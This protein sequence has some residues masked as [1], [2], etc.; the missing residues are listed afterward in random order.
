MHLVSSNKWLQ[1]AD[2]SVKW[3]LQ[4]PALK[5]WKRYAWNF[6]FCAIGSDKPVKQKLA[7]WKYLDA[8]LMHCKRF[9]ILNKKKVMRWTHQPPHQEITSIF[10]SK[11]AKIKRIQSFNPFLFS[12]VC[13]STK[14]RHHLEMIRVGKN[15]SRNQAFIFDR[16]SAG[17]LKTTCFLHIP[18]PLWGTPPHLGF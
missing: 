5:V 11:G 6:T 15:F 7:F 16:F 9:H 17:R 2:L 10:I 8:I 3:K 1:I 4:P 13:P 12:F 14:V 18:P